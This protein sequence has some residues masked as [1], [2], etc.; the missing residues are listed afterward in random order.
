MSTS[1]EFR[2]L[3]NRHFE[4]ASSWQNQVVTAVAI[5]VTSILTLGAFP[6]LLECKISMLYVGR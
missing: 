6:L 1:T 2:I 5:L 4:S 3:A